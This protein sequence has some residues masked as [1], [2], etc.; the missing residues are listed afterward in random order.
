MSL[1]SRQRPLRAGICWPRVKPARDPGKQRPVGDLN[2]TF[3]Y[4]LGIFLRQFRS[5]NVKEGWPFNKMAVNLRKHFAFF[6]VVVVAVVLINL[7][8]LY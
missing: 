8:F 6:V 2:C 1:W 4:S 7:A 5:W 3:H